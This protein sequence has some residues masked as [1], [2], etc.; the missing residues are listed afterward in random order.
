M[1]D[2]TVAC[3]TDAEVT[4]VPRNEL[5][6]ASKND[7]YLQQ[8][9]KAQA[10]LGRET[11]RQAAARRDEAQILPMM[12]RAA[13]AQLAG[14]NLTPRPALVPPRLLSRWLAVR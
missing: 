9:A 13:V 11:A 14:P 7:E 8:T 12:A 1:H 6:L 5:R 10:E 4:V 2:T 3:L